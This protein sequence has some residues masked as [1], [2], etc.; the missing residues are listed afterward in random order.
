MTQSRFDS[1]LE[2]TANIT[3]GYLVALLSQLLIFPHFGI[4]LPL[5][6]NLLIGGWFTLISFLRGYILRR[7]FNGLHFRKAKPSNGPL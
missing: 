1:L 4:N 6:S 5:S 3:I 7:W 2:T